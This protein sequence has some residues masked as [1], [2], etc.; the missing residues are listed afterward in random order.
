MAAIILV[1]D[2]IVG[3]MIKMRPVVSRSLD[4]LCF[5]IFQLLH[6]ILQVE[7]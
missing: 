4:F 7:S 1:T 6:N 2:V 5:S 3:A